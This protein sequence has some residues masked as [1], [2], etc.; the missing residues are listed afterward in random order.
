MQGYGRRQ[1]WNKIGDT[2]K[3]KKKYKSM[4]NLK[5]NGLFIDMF[6]QDAVHH[7]EILYNL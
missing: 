3:K 6:C 5:V 7:Q 4:V 1:G 2:K